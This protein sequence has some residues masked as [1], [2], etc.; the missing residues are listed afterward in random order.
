MRLDNTKKFV[1]SLDLPEI[2]EL[3]LAFLGPPPRSR[4]SCDSLPHSPGKAVTAT[5]ISHLR[6]SQTEF[7]ALSLSDSLTRVLSQKADSD[8]AELVGLFV[9]CLFISNYNDP[10]HQ[11]EKEPEDGNSPSGGCNGSVSCRSACI[12]LLLNSLLSSQPPMHSAM[13]AP[14]QCEVTKE[15]L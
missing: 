8:E 13:K 3:Q 9:C 14:D 2:S 1:L 6:K 11:K 12:I 5:T 10:R 4:R 15:D 7:A